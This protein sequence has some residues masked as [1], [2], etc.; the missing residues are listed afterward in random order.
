MIVIQWRGLLRIEGPITEDCEY[1]FN[2][3]GKLVFYTSIKEGDYLSVFEYDSGVLLRRI[4]FRIT[5]KIPAAQPFS[6]KDLPDYRVTKFVS[7]A[8]S[9]V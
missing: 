4:D 2:E 6:L 3:D 5:Q 9:T 1:K 7:S 8:S